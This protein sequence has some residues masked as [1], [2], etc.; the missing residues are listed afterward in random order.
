MPNA[1]SDASSATKIAGAACSMCATRAWLQRA[2]AQFVFLAVD[3][4]PL[5][6]HLVFFDGGRIA[7]SLHGLAD[8]DHFGGGAA[9]VHAEG[10]RERDGPHLV[11]ALHRDQGMRIFILQGLDRAADGDRVS[12]VVAAPAVMGE[13][14]AARYERKGR[15][16]SEGFDHGYLQMRIGPAWQI[17]PE[18]S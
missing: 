17:T 18:F 13:R 3:L 4:D 12:R 14:G 8:G 6:A 15:D 2:S 11:G 10:G 7:V 1:K 5:D 16:D 9:A